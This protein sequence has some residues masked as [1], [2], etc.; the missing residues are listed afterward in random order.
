MKLNQHFK[1]W[2]QIVSSR[3]AHLS[4]PPDRAERHWLAMSVAMLWI[5]PIGGEQEVYEDE[6]LISDRFD[7]SQP[8]PTSTPTPRLSCFV[9][10]LL[11]IIEFL[12]L[13]VKIIFLSCLLSR[14]YHSHLLL[15]KLALALNQRHLTTTLG[16]GRDVGGCLRHKE[17]SVFPKSL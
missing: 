17:P 5:L 14:D 1:D 8:L 4:L 12:L 7:S 10:G 6:Q 16:R 2:K 3:F 9:N 11:T 15:E 13:W